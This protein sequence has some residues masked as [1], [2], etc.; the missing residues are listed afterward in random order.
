MTGDREPVASGTGADGCSHADKDASTSAPRSLR[1]LLGSACGC[2]RQARDSYA[3]LLQLGRGVTGVRREAYDR[4]AWWSDAT[5]KGGSRVFIFA[6]RGP[7]GEDMWLPMWELGAY[8]LA[9]MHKHVVEE[10]KPFAVVWAQMSDHRIWPWS[11]AQFRHSLHESYRRNFEAVHLLHPSWSCRFLTL[12]LWPIAADE[13]WDCFQSHER[14]EF[15]IPLMAGGKLELPED[16]LEYDKL[17]DKQ[18]QEA[19]EVARARM[20]GGAGGAFGGLGASA[21]AGSAASKYE[22]EM[23]KLFE[24]LK[25][26]GHAEKKAD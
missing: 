11:F 3:E 17:L 4:M 6:P 5:T 25:R 16:I 24:E 8:A 2:R 19:T 10:D 9:K 1:R 18:G 22:A 20:G 13:F 21:A 15:L 26:K 7:N 12:A 23:N 14:V